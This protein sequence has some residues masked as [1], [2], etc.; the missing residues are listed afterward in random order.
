MYISVYTQVCV[1]VYNSLVVG[2]NAI[3]FSRAKTKTESQNLKFG[4]EKIRTGEG[5][6][7]PK[8]I[9]DCTKGRI[10]IDIEQ[11]NSGACCT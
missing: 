7:V 6:R 5:E 9:V 3:F 8:E 10:N 2:K 1:Y 4:E 11:N